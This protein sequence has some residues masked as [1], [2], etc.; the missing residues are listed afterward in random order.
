MTLPF[1]SVSRG[2]KHDLEAVLAGPWFIVMGICE[3]ESAANGGSRCSTLLELATVDLEGD[4][5]WER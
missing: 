3:I 1:W 2:T 4:T 5:S